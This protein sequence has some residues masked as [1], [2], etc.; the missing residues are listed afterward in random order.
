[1]KQTVKTSKRLCTSIL[2]GIFM[3]LLLTSCGGDDN[4]SGGVG[5]SK[6][7]TGRWKYIHWSS[8]INEHNMT[9]E[10]DWEHKCDTDYDYMDIE[11]DG[12][13]EMVFYTADC[14][15]SGG[16][17]GTLE[18]SGNILEFNSSGG[19]TQEREIIEITNTILKIQTVS[20]LRTEVITYQK[21]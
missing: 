8:T 15:R 16:D 13:Y 1:M 20:E 10:E 6:S 2:T 12:S 17:S 19:F 14:E 21:Q 3:L 9:S 11:E 7:I 4:S 5:D 18:K